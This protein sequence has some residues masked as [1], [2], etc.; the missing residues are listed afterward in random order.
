MVVGR[1][2]F[3][4]FWMRNVSFT[5]RSMH[6]LDLWELYTAWRPGRLYVQNQ[7]KQHHM[8]WVDCLVVSGAVF[9]YICVRRMVSDYSSIGRVT[10]QTLVKRYVVHRIPI[11]HRMA[12]LATPRCRYEDIWRMSRNAV[13]NFA[14]ETTP[15]NSGDA[16]WCK[17][18]QKGQKWLKHTFKHTGTN[19]ETNTKSICDDL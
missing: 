5:H 13:K 11:R 6:S 7:S 9:E 15:F 1:T 14:F 18:D 10:W 12:Y 2:V 4:E 3:I 8:S 16:W 17:S 19:I